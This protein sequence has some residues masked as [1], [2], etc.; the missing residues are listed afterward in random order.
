MTSEEEIKKILE[1][2]QDRDSFT[3]FHV[4]FYSDK[5]HVFEN[6]YTYYEHCTW[7]EY[8]P[9]DTGRAGADL[10]DDWM[11]SE[12]NCPT[13]RTTTKWIQRRL[14]KPEVSRLFY[15]RTQALKYAI[16]KTK[17]Y[18]EV[19][20]ERLEVAQAQLLKLREEIQNQ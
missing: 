9:H 6:T 12:N 11:V 5:Y 18:N 7:A 4:S 19:L 15:T 3:L 16:E 13:G 2:P 1:D 10:I 14:N 20:R 17:Q 8:A